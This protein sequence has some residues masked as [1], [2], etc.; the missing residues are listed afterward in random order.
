MARRTRKAGISVPTTSMGDIAFLL[1]IFFMICSNFATDSGINI[2]PARS[3]HLESVDRTRIMVH[4][5]DD[6]EIYLMGQRVQNAEDVEWGV[7]SLIEK[8]TTDKAKVVRFKCDKDVDKSIF[9]DVL[10]AIEKGGGQIQAVGERV[11][12][13]GKYQPAK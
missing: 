5:A 13:K 4:I 2:K 3:A 11:G 10:A 6:N 9:E 8:A 7:R 12:P 1:I